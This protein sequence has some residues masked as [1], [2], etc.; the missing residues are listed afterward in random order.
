VHSGTLERLLSRDELAAAQLKVAAC[1]EDTLDLQRSCIF[2][3]CER[4]QEED[5]AQ[6][7]ALGGW[8][9]SAACHVRHLEV[10][11][12]WEDDNALHDMLINERAQR[13]ERGR[14]EGRNDI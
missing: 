12:A 3:E 14:A 7:R 10:A 9:S 8:S 6:C 4:L 2:R 11:G 5:A 1:S 13:S